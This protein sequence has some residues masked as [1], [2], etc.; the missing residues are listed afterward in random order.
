[1]TNEQTEI[2]DLDRR[3]LKAA[4]DNHIWLNAFGCINPSV[5]FRLELADEILSMLNQ[6]ELLLPAGE[7]RIGELTPMLYLSINKS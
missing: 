3:K 7:C 6:K 2:T 5:A 4:G 1:M